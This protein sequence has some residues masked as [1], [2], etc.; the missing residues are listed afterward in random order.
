MKLS[1]NLT[2]YFEDMRR[3]RCRRRAIRDALEA[4]E[5][6][7]PA[8]TRFDLPFLTGRGAAA[9]ER[10]D[11]QALARAWTA[12]FRYRDETRRG[13]DVRRLTLAAQTFLELLERA[14]AG[15]AER[16]GTGGLETGT[17]ALLKE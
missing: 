12:Q 7:H 16:P 3:R 6:C 5:G 14:G 15:C 9:L 8:E 1:E 10:G 17:L 11:A 4:F 13:E 2:Y